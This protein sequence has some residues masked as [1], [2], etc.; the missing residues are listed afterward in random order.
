[1]E[2]VES[3]LAVGEM[4]VGIE[5]LNNLTVGGGVG[6]MDLS[7]AVRFGEGSG[8][9]HEEIGLAGDGIV[10]SGEGLDVGQFGVVEVATKGEG[11]VSGEMTV[12]EGNLNGGGKRIPMRLVGMR[13][14]CGGQGDV[15]I[16]G[17]QI[18]GNLRRGQRTAHA[19]IEGGAA[20]QCDW[21]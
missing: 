11:G 3:D 7:L 8:S 20:L 5:P 2:V 17:L 16:V 19:A 14:G 15:E 1:M 12:L 18:P 13:V 4:K 21:K 10:E 9:L 6:E